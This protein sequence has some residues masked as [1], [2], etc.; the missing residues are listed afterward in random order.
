MSTVSP[1][2]PVRSLQCMEIWGGNQAVDQAVATPGLDVW[3]HSRPYEQA[4][5]GGDVYY[6]SLCGGGT[7]TRLILADVCGHG[8]LVAGVA[9]ALRALMRK[10]IN[11]K[12]QA[13][14]V[15]ALNREFT[16][17]AECERF[18][19]AVVATYLT[20]TNRLAVCN[21]GHPRPLRYSA[22]T[23]AWSLLRHD[24]AA[25]DGGVADLPL[26]LVDEMGYTQVEFELGRGDLV[27]FYTDALTEAVSPDGRMLEEDGLLELVRGLDPA[28]PAAFPAALVSALDAF[29]GGAPANDDATFVLLHHNAGP[30]RRPGL[31]DLVDVYAKV[32]GLRAV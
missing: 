13:R 18:A 25:A 28:A 32:L 2:S 22:G 16:A 19:T 24:A 11:R 7:I 15:R 29:R 14:L 23:G 17:L 9:K 1:P 4:T 5:H 31:F 27:L 8:P 3:V 12:A 30:A 10:Y 6:A 26:G 21:A 20:R